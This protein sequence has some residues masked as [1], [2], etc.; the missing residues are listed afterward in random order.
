MINWALTHIPQLIFL[1]VLFS[2]IRAVVRA[3]QLSA[4]DRA[5]AQHAADAFKPGS[6]DARANVAPTMAEALRK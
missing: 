1:F 6:L 4:D 5:A 2:V 3:T